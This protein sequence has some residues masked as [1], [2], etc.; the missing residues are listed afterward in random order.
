MNLFCFL[1]KRRVVSKYMIIT[2]I[3]GSQ[4]GMNGTT[5]EMLKYLG[6]GIMKGNGT[7][8]IIN[9]L[10][11]HIE[12][13]RGCFACWNEKRG[14]CVIKD[15][16]YQLLNIIRASDMIFLATPV[17]Y[18]NVTIVMKKFLE[19]LL[20][21]NNAYVKKCDDGIYRHRCEDKIPSIV[22]V[23]SC[24][25]SDYCNFDIISLYGKTIAQHLNTKVIAEIYRTEGSLFKTKIQNIKLVVNEYKKVWIKAGYELAT[26][27][28]LSNMT[29]RDIKR[30]LLKK[31]IYIEVGNR[32][33]DN[34]EQNY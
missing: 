25:L 16:M 17:Y 11:Q 30:P 7:F 6:E 24:S 19:R 18:H 12:Q 31:E 3:N 27:Q 23:S 33:A 26:D 20:P 21:L 32:L 13:C 10:D 15:D 1:M 2:A 4:K 14:S 34:K 9:L 8:D 29:L 28:C 22:M 5:Y